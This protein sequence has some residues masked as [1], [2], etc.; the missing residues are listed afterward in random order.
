MTG[1]ILSLGTEALLCY[2][3]TASTFRAVT[4]QNWNWLLLRS[5]VCN[6]REGCEETVVFIETGDHLPPLTLVLSLLPSYAPAPRAASRHTCIWIDDKSIA[7][8][9]LR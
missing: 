2:E 8:I 5:M 9:Y 6:L 1:R 3:A 7:L 4:L